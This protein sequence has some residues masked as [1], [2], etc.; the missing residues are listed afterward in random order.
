MRAGVGH[1]TFHSRVG[2]LVFNAWAKITI[3]RKP[4]E[5]FGMIPYKNLNVKLTVCLVSDRCSTIIPDFMVL[6][7]VLEICTWE[8]FIE[9]FFF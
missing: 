2:H 8:T 9:V 1:P 5:S 4:N 6:E 7:M 3:L